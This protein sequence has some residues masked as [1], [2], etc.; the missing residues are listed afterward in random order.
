MSDAELEVTLAEAL[1]EVFD[2]E[3]GYNVVGLGL[4]Y[5]IEVQSGRARIE[6]TTTTR[7]CPAADYI[8]EGVATRAESVAGISAVEVVMTWDPPW[9]P[10]RMTPEAKEHFGV[11]A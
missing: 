4:V 3:L 9:S 8:R 7:G 1:T 2:P 10:E 11:S 5:G 6:L